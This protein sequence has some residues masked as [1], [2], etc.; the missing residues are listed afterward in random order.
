M[1][2]ASQQ[3]AY[4]AAVEGNGQRG[5]GSTGVLLHV[6]AGN[7]QQGANHQGSVDRVVELIGRLVKAIGD[8][9]IEL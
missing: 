5:P 4:L 9:A 2:S 1:S 8:E 7:V 3:Q 6:H